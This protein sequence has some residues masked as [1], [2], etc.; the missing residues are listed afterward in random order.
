MGSTCRPGKCQSASLPV[1]TATVMS[2]HAF[3]CLYMLFYPLFSLSLPRISRSDYG[4]VHPPMLNL[5]ATLLPLRHGSHCG[6][7]CLVIDKLFALP[8]LDHFADIL[9]RSY[10]MH[11]SEREGKLVLCMDAVIKNFCIV[12]SFLGYFV[13]LC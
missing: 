12:P 11:K 10:F 7:L 13:R 1:V 4:R 8:L 2:P 6:R 3:V 9:F 5:C